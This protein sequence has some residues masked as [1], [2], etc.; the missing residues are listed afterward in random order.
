MRALNGE[1]LLRAWDEGA[2]RDDLLRGMIMLSL[3]LDEEDPGRPLNLPLPECNRLL[4]QLREISFGP[5]LE[6]FHRC[7]E[8]GE[9]S[10][11]S[12]PIAVLRSELGSNRELAE[13][14]WEEGGARYRMRQAT[15]DD[16][17]AVR[18]IADAEEAQAALI[19]R[20]LLE[21]EMPSEQAPLVERFEALHKGAEMS[22]MLV[23]PACAH[24]G[25]FDL[26]IMRFLWRET[27]AAALRL[28]EE[29]HDLAWAYG[30]SEASIVSMSGVRRAAY[31]EMVRA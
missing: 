30:W 27:R 13:A 31:L 6:G 9:A 14:S 24:K 28:L 11:F 2:E 20:C 7:P 3:A 26:D 12:I 4:L 5:I 16:M 23:C 17:L 29:V 19:H 25:G 15:P 22:C 18:N 10:E 1:L 8:C 21:G